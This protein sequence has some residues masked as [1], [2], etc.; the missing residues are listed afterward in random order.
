MTIDQKLID[1]IRALLAKTE[2][3]GCTPEEAESAFAMAQRL[4]AKHSIE[5]EALIA[6]GHDVK[7][8]PIINHKVSVRKRDEVSRQRVT[9][10]AAIAAANNCKVIDATDDYDQVWI[11]GHESEALFVEILASAVLMQYA[12]ERNRGWKQWK[13]EYPFSDLSRFKWVSGFAWGY[14]T[15]V[16]ERLEKEVEQTVAGEGA[17][18]EL[19]FVGRK[20][21]VQDWVDENLSTK[22]SKARSVSYNAAA[23]AMGEDAA[24]RADL[25][26]GRG[27]VAGNGRKALS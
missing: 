16:A 20:A 8:E 6:A 9:I 14:A 24:N 18:K 2:E 19:V 22:K 12:T 1:K 15:R 23:G 10:I 27:H 17:G 26:G 3:N 5:E 4:M 21:L 25:S 11:V 13:A 7:R